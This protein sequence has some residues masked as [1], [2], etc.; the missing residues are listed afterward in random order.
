[1]WLAFSAPSHAQPSTPVLTHQSNTQPS[2]RYVYTLLCDGSFKY[3]VQQAGY[4]VILY[5]SSGIA[6]DRRAGRLVCKEPLVAEAWALLVDARLATSLVGSINILSGCQVLLSTM[7]RPPDSWPWTCSSLH[8][9]ISMTFC[10]RSRL[11]VV[12]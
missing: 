4:G 12:D 8:P 9:S 7:V 2:N 5:N 10:P 3:D 1:M 6:T 11:V